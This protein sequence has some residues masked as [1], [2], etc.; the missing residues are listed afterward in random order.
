PAG[1]EQCG[2][3]TMN[4][5]L[6]RVSIV[7]LAMFLA[8][9]TSTML[10]QVITSDSLRADDRNSRTLYDSYSA[11]RGPILVDGQ[12]IAV[13]VPTD[14]EYKFQRTYTN[15][16]LYAPVTGYFTLNQG[17]TGIEGALNDYLS[18]T[19]N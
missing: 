14:D 13:S 7:V 12:P 1:R 17:N 16:L 3:G 5:E 4:K 6:K 9:F 10:I 2:G 15:P 19:S 18:G 11:E 8:L